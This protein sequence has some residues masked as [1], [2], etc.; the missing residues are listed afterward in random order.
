MTKKE[1]D[2]AIFNYETIL[3]NYYEYVAICL[4]KNLINESESN[5]YF[6]DLLKSVKEYF[7][8]SLLF[9]KELAK[10]EEYPGIQWLLKKWNIH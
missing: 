1:R 6:R 10:K 4:Y 9:E 8:S 3:F 5:L 7:E 2:I